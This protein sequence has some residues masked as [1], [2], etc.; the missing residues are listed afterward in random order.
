MRTLLVA[1]L[2]IGGSALVLPIAAQDSRSP[3]ARGLP[4]VGCWEAA[5][6]IEAQGRV[7]V[8]PERDRD[9]R[10]VSFD[11]QGNMTESTLRLNAERAPVSSGDCT[12]W[13]QAR[14]SADGD[15]ILVDAQIRCGDSPQQTRTTAFVMTPAGYWLQVNGSGVSMVAN[16]RIRLYRQVESYAE[17]P[18]AIRAAVT[19]HVAEAEYARREMLD[20]AVSVKDLVELE[21]MGVA[22]A[23]IDLV[24]AAS[25]PKFFVI[26]PQGTM[27]PAT[28]AAGGQSNASAMRSPFYW[29][30]GFPMFS[31]YDMAMLENCMRFG[32]RPIGGRRY[33][34]SALGWQGDGN[35]CF[36]GGLYGGYYGGYG[37]GSGLPVVVRPVAAPSGDVPGNGGGGRAV[38]GRGYTSGN[39][40]TGTRSA[41]P[42]SGNEGTSRDAGSSGSSTSAG[43]GGSAGASGSSSGSSGERTAKP[44]NP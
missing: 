26:D 23:V 6:G 22:T 11:R 16:T 31:L 12:G 33:G 41:S 2:A 29:S 43:S 17:F 18:A 35:G 32:M 25:Y 1:A 24:V 39:D 3:D 40:N 30:N 20:R 8:I 15:R 14:L 4:W 21:E 38:R 7:C 27:S 34:Y 28:P 37:P 42:R 5:D 36:D 10:I 44:R 13:E 9:L 19:P